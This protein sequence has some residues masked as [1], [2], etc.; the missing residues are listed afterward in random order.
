MQANPHGSS[1]LAMSLALVYCGLVAYASLYPFTGWQSQ[2]VMPW[3]FVMSP[4]PRYWSGFD[5]A[6]NV[7][8][9]MPLGFL[10]TVAWLGAK[11]SHPIGAALLIALLISFVMEGLQTYLA[12][13]VASNVDWA[14]NTFGGTLGGM[15]AWMADGLGLLQSWSRFRG[16]SFSAQSGLA[17]GL[18]FLWPL[19]L[20]YPTPV[21][22]GLGAGLG[23]WLELDTQALSYKA[24]ATILALGLLAPLLISYA[25]TPKRVYR[26]L[27]LLL[28]FAAALG[29]TTLSNGLSFGPEH[30]TVWLHT[31]SLQG[32]W[33]GASAG[34][35]LLIVSNRWAWVL[36]FVCLVLELTLVCLMPQDPYFAQT[37]AIWEQGR[38]IRFYGATQW[39][40]LLW[41]YAALIL[42]TLHLAGRDKN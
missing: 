11:R 12:P 26:V 21:P 14:L 28:I 32:L 31:Q 35:L 1:G 18:L 34:V 22:L 10:I 23:R 6:M 20:L 30:A 29:I 13:R 36:A 27:A 33:I 38:F 16:R 3:A 39:L 9:Y 40:G 15:L 42:I 5:V 2:G 17:L 25:V 24:E 4:L 41:P 7:L 37:L 19:A 8:G